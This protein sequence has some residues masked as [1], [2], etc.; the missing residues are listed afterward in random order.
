MSLSAA[1]VAVLALSDP[2]IQARDLAE[3]MARGRDVGVPMTEILDIVEG[4][5]LWSS[6]TILIY[7]SPNIPPVAVGTMV[8]A[9]C[10]G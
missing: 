5:R 4:D 8:E 1:I 3:T 9:A 2:C 6:L 7:T 10:R